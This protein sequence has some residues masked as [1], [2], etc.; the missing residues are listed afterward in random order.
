M[1]GSASFYACAGPSYAVAPTA[2]ISASVAP[3]VSSPSPAPIA[4]A[5]H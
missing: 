1:E 4:T 5:A 2:A 3:I